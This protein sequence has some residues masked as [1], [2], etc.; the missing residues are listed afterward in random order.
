MILDAANISL[1]YNVLAAVFSWF[2]LSGFVIFPGTYSS[3][4]HSSLLHETQA[5]QIVEAVVEN[6]PLVW[7]ASLCC[8]VGLSGTIWLGY[9]FR[10]NFAWLS[11]RIAM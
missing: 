1:R 9:I 3:L 6:L 4:G 7:V 2:T 8:A 11:D 10:L 5:G